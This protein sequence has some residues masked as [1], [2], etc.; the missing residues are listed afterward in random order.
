MLGSLVLNALTN[1]QENVTVARRAGE[2]LTSGSNNV[3]VGGVPRMGPPL[4]VA[5]LPSN[6]AG[7]NDGQTS[8]MS[9]ASAPRAISDAGDYSRTE[10]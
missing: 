10:A 8:I 5:Y 3:I 6:Q 2:F 7:A 9:F 4:E 1:S